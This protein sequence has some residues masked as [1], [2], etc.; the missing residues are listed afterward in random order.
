M[1][2]RYQIEAEIVDIT[3][4]NPSVNDQFLVDTNVW[5]WFTY[6]K[7][8]LAFNSSF[9][10]QVKDYPAYLKKALRQKAELFRTNLSLAEIAHL[11][12]TSERE[13]FVKS[14][15]NVKPKEYRHNYDAER[16]KV[17]NQIKAV[18]FQIKSI[19][20]PIDL[21]LNDAFTDSALARMQT[22][23]LDG[24]DLFMLESLTKLGITNIITDD[25]DYVTVPSIRVF[26]ANRN[27]I[28]TARLQA[29]LIT[30]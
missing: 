14:G 2:V 5:Y 4:D 25:G 28:N 1:P 24:Y 26:T 27:V 22:Q 21:T 19:A 13:I 20:Q 10:Y 6:N 8:G 12:E 7:S 23:R 9:N 11:I 3:T 18:W 15:N 29:K 16:S 30:R 17:V